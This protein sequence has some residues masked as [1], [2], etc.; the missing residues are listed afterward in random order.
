MKYDI[1]TE[2][3][4]NGG[5][6]EKFREWIE[7]RWTKV[8]DNRDIDWG[9]KPRELRNVLENDSGFFHDLVVRFLH[10]NETLCPVLYAKLQRILQHYIQIQRK[11]LID[12]I[13]SILSGQIKRYRRGRSP[14]NK[15]NLREIPREAYKEFIK[16]LEYRNEIFEFLQKREEFSN[17][18][19]NLDCL[20]YLKIKF[21]L[22]KPYISK[23]DE[24]F[25]PIDNPICKEKVFGG[26]PYIR[27][28]I[29]KGS[30]RHVNYKFFIDRLE[31]GD[32]DENNWKD[33]RG[34]LVR[35]FGNEKDNLELYVDYVLA[36][37]LDKEKKELK[38]EFENFLRSKYK[39][40][41]GRAGRLI[42]F[43]TFFDQISLDVIAPHD[44]K[45]RAITKRGPIPLE[46]AIGSG[47]F[48][49]I[50]LPFDIIDDES[51]L[52]KEVKEDLK[53]LKETIPKMMLEYGFSAKKTSGYG[54]VEDE[55]EFWI[56]NNHYKGTFKEFKEKM[57][58]LIS[59]IGD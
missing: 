21:T 40:K 10:N 38:R 54:V 5:L 16:Q 45:S 59:E 49:L 36:K 29:W 6:N 58:E 19:D 53:L 52:K 39:I 37:K 15:L 12:F 42:F 26:V 8:R 56:N 7:D 2:F 31:K 34:K 46:V 32:I 30:L 24:E 55:I 43:P 3:W 33:E 51:R 23:D 25:Y 44:R 48:K 50:Y 1:Y 47:E 57:H 41:D 14:I 18:W 22:S 35:L 4:E 9:K 13:H 20:I 11:D 27:S 17:V 28:T